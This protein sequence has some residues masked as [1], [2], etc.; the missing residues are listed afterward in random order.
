VAPRDEPLRLRHS[1][2][3][4]RIVVGEGW[5]S[6]LVLPSAAEMHAGSPSGEGSDQWAAMLQVLPRIEGSWGTGRVL[7]GT[8]FS[9][10]LA[11]DGRV[12]VGAVTPELLEAALA[13][14]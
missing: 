11:D 8:L 1:Q 3:E 12:A 14:Q 4:T 2:G 5:T 6:V 13:A 7:D 9:A 10:I